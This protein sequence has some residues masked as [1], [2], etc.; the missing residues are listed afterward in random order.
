MLLSD[1]VL[2]LLESPQ[3]VYTPQD[4]FVS[5]NALSGADKARL[6][7]FRALAGKQVVLQ[8]LDTGS[9]HT[10]YQCWSPGQNTL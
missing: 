2:E 5:L 7:K 6:I 1:E 4:V 8:L 3:P 10:F 9:S